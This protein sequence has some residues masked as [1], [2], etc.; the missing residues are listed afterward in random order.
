META[1]QRPVIFL[2]AQ[3]SIA[4]IP[5]RKQ[6]LADRATGYGSGNLD[7]S[8][9]RPKTVHIERQGGGEGRSPPQNGVDV[10]R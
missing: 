8:S 3:G 4:T 2:I 1:G 6:E 5:H 9:L 10:P 7:K